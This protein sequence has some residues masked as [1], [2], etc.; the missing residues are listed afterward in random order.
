MHSSSISAEFD[1]QFPLAK[2]SFY[3]FGRVQVL[4][5]VREEIIKEL[6]LA[7]QDSHSLLAEHIIRAE[8]LSWL[9]V[10][11]AYEVVRTMSQ[12]KQCFSER[13]QVALGGIKKE[14]SKV[15]MPSAKMEQ[16]GRYVAVPSRRSPA[17]L[18]VHER[19]LKIGDPGNPHSLR[20]L[21]DQFAKV[22]T[23]FEAADILDSHES[24]YPV[25]GGPP[26]AAR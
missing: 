21:L 3:A 9:W 2:Y 7:Y 24:A 6:D 17:A 8:S 15:R 12:A 1:S 13:A 26:D 19:D 22:F 5:S 16:Q 25:T 11:G 20:Q 10:L 23:S 4:M 18:A 14:L